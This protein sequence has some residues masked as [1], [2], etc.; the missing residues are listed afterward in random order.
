MGQHCAQSSADWVRAFPC[1][2]C[3]TRFLSA[4]LFFMLCVG[5]NRCGPVQ[6]P[7]VPGSTEVPCWGLRGKPPVGSGPSLGHPADLCSLCSC[8]GSGR[9][10]MCLAGVLYSRTPYEPAKPKQISCTYSL[11]VNL[12]CACDA[13]GHLGK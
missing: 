12:S 5:L 4:R 7:L 2:C 3:T 8:Q 10:D 1:G 11:V 6:V 9:S 13:S